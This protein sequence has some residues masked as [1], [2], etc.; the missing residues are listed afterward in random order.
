MLIC[1]IEITWSKQFKLWKVLTVIDSILVGDVVTRFAL[2]Y[3]VCDFKATQMNVQCNLTWKF[4]SYKFELGHNTAEAAE[5]TVDHNSVTRW[6]KKF[7]LGC[8]NLNDQTRSGRPK[9]IDSKVMIHG[10]KYGKYY[11]E[12]SR[13]LTVTFTTKTFRAAELCIM[14]PKYCKTFHSSLFLALSC[15]YGLQ[16]TNIYIYIY[17]YIYEIGLEALISSYR[18]W[19]LFNYYF[20]Y[21]SVLVH[22][23]SMKK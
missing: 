19:M 13:H 6:F 3:A 4:I 21:F 17:I 1:F 5:S 10:G 15:I 9:S 14:L 7:G 23:K 16:G 18:N 11:S 22:E 12:S 8:K 2:L 20:L